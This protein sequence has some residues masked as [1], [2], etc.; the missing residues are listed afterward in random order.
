MEVGLVEIS[1]FGHV[2]SAGGLGPGLMK[3]LGD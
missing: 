1:Y 3:K 2:L